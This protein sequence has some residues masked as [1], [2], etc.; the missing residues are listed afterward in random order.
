MRVVIVSLGKGCAGRRERTQR[1]NG[2]GQ[3]KR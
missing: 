1:E 3:Q 2:G